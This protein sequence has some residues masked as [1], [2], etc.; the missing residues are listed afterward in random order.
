M[1]VEQCESL[2]LRR[3]GFLI[4][5]I[6]ARECPFTLSCSGD[7]TLP[8]S[9]RHDRP[10]GFTLRQIVASLPPMSGGVSSRR[11][12]SGLV[13][14]GLRMTS[15]VGCGATVSWLSYSLPGLLYVPR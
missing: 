3:A 15:E 14:S 7:G 8:R 4:D 12:M 2:P 1:Q 10:S 5:Y 13:G 11:L 6:I 9:M